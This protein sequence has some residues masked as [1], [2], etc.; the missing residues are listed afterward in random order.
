MNA[1]RMVLTPRSTGA[2]ATAVCSDV[3]LDIRVT[4]ADDLDARTP[5]QRQIDALMAPSETAR[6]VLIG[7]LE[8][9]FADGVHLAGVSLYANFAAASP[10]DGSA[11]GSGEPVWIGFP[12]LAETDRDVI[13][14]EAEV[15]VA[16]SRERRRARVRINARSP[17]THYMLADGLTL[18]VDASGA[19][20]ELVADNVAFD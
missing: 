13:H 5:V 14:V 10:D 6:R 11:A 4:Y 7:D 3:T 2:R 15:A 16:V 17:A 18:G 12:D 8:F 9:Y 1:P 19:I 20:A